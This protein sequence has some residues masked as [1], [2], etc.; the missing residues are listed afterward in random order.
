M[1]TIL[2]FV[3]LFSQNAFSEI[4]LDEIQ[5]KI[6]E[7]LPTSTSRWKLA[8]EYT[9][10]IRDP[11][12]QISINEDCHPL[13]EKN[14]EVSKALKKYLSLELTDEIKS[15]FSDNPDTRPG[16]VV[17]R[18][19]LSGNVI[20]GEMPIRGRFPKFEEFCQFSDN[21]FISTN[22][23]AFYQGPQQIPLPAEAPNEDVK[24][25]EVQ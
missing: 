8:G 16:V 1:K 3:L 19:L 7:A 10:I 13:E 15:L 25:V 4:S 14:C 24:A 2:F 5:E 23:L 11:I 6:K 21:S 17:C 9:T 22:S 18:D 12:E 20:I